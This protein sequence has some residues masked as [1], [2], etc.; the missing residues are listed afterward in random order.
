[1]VGKMMETCGNSFVMVRGKNVG[2]TDF[3]D[4]F[5]NP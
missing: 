3:R 1:M 4:V 2:S 5:V